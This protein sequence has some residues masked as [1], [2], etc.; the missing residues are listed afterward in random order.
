MAQ[1]ASAAHDKIILLAEDDPF[2]SRMYQVKLSG[3]GF[4]VI[5]K[6]NGREAYEAIKSDKP[7]LIML[8]INMPELSGLEVLSALASD[9]FDFSTTPTIV[10]T[11]SSSMEDRK[12]AE[13]YGAEYLVKA[14]LTPRQVLD[15]IDDKLGIGHA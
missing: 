6:T 10:L 15:L 3:A 12:K 14:E 7:S 2:I 9:S 5:T 11:N 13:Q 4:T 8:D 1:S